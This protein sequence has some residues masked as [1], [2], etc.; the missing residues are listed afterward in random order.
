MGYAKTYEEPSIGISDKVLASAD[1]QEGCSVGSFAMNKGFTL[2]KAIHPVCYIRCYFEYENTAG[3][4][5]QYSLRVNGTE[6]ASGFTNS[7]VFLPVTND[8]KFTGLKRGDVI[9]FWFNSADA[10]GYCKNIRLYGT[11]TPFEANQL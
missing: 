2:I 1:V 10:N 5:I 4:I 9:G 8:Q 3:S 11:E 7:I 6:F